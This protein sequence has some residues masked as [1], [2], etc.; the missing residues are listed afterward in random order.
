VIAAPVQPI[1]SSL[2][3]TRTGS[4]SLGLSIGV[5]AGV[6]SAWSLVVA[7][8]L[9]RSGIPPSA[10][11][12]HYLGSL[13]LYA[14]V[15]AVF[16]ALAVGL[17]RLELSLSRFRF[18]ARREAQLAPWFYGVVAALGSVSTAIWTFSTDKL[19][20]SPLRIVGPIV[21]AGVCGVA[22]VV[23][24]WIILRGF[25]SVLARGAGYLVIAGILFVGGAVTAYLD[26]TEYVALYPRLH[27][28]ME[29]VAALLFGSAYALWLRRL[30]LGTLSAR[31]LRAL[32]IVAGV[33][34]ALTIVWSQP[35]TWFDDSLK[36]VWLEEAYVGRMLRRLQ[37]AETFFSDPF[38]WPGMHMAR[39][40]RVKTRYSLRNTSVAPEWTEPLTEPPEVWDALRQ[41]RAGQTRYDVIVYY[42]D[43]L[44]HDAAEDP[45]LMPSLRGFAERSL[46]FRRAY[47]VGSDT[48]RSL[49]ALT[50]GNYDVSQTPEND[51]LRVAKRANYETTLV[52]AKSAH[53]FL[54]KLRPE[55]AFE[56]ARAVEDYPADLQVW[57]Y[58]AQQPTARSLVD[59]ALGELDKKRNRP[60]LLWMFNFDQHNWAQLDQEH[61]ENQARRFGIQD[62]P[63]KLAFRYRAVAR[64]ID[65]EFG[66]LLRGLE[67]RKRLDKTVILFVSDH[68]EAMGRD[69]FWMHSVFLWE[70]LIRVPLVLHVPGVAPKRVND[71]VSL[72]DVAP[73]LG[74]YFDP[75]LNGRGFHGQDLLG[76]A[77]PEPPKRRF[78]LLV[79]GAS[80]DVLVRVGFVD[81]GSQYKLVLS[82]EAALPELYDL[83]GDDPDELNL[84]F[85]K[86]PRVQKGLELLARSPI[87]PRTN[88]DFE[89][90]DTREQKAAS[91]A[92]AV[93]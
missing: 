63:D 29:F 4:A 41:L 93:P 2:D 61:V 38:N 60:L 6:L 47:A 28:L 90:R 26:L 3:P 71:K 52:I 48:L 22:G 33:W 18:W 7:D 1:V 14:A 65:A 5:V 64:S 46:D 76:Y 50:G 49:P 81:P 69:G 92:S 10:L 31:G 23:G 15:G 32:S 20:H 59:R 13:G 58:G 11:S 8:A 19:E 37:V 55:F 75:T 39:I 80:K 57:G 91:L 51:L 44:R 17:V 79:V 74:R 89:M 35:R 27:T 36:H 78:P 56:N 45:A 9:V 85:S 53:E 30:S 62:Q 42:V 12:G 66:R 16:G 34:C 70:E 84:A 40:E 21:M 77:L 67:E 54:S 87:F 25:A 68:G 43:S 83:S 72:V 88:D 73:T 24:S 82:L 86:M